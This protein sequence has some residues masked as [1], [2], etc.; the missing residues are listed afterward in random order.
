MVDLYAEMYPSFHE[1]FSN[2]D[3][4]CKT[5]AS[6]KDSPLSLYLDRKEVGVKWILNLPSDSSQLISPSIS[7]PN[8]QYNKK[9]QTTTPGTSCPTELYMTIDFKIQRDW[10]EILC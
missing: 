3:V 10:F 4:Y 9:D 7:H 6:V 8:P 2:T 1:T 5:D